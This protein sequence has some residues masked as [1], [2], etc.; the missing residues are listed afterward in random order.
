MLP[1]VIDRVTWSVLL[2][3]RLSVTSVNPAKTAEPIEILFC[4][5]PWWALGTMY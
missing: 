5:G 2:S 3:V 4:C 1:V